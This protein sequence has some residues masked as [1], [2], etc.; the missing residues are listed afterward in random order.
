MRFS[1][2]QEIKKDTSVVD[3]FGGLNHNIRINDGEFFDMENLTSENFPV[4]SPRRKRGLYAYPEEGRHKVNG[5]TAKDV[6]CYVDNSTLYIDNVPVDGFELT[7]TPKTMVSMGAYLIIMPDKKYINTKDFEDN[8]SLEASFATTGITT[9]TM[10]RVDGTEYENVTVSDTAPT[11]PENMAYWIDTSQEPHILKQF[12]SASDSWTVIN[13]TYVRIASAGIAEQFGQYD[14]VRL[15]GINASIEQLKDLEGQTSILWEVHRDEEGDGAGDYIVVVGFLD[16]VVTQDT[17]LEAKRLMPI[18]DFIIES[19]NRL[20]GCRYGTD[21]DGNTVNEIY[22]SKLGDFKNWNSFMGISTDSYAAS[23]GTDGEFTGAVTHGGY[24]LFFK[25]NYLHKVYGNYPANFQV[26]VTECRGVQ[27]GAGRSLAILN[28]VLVYKSRYGVCRYDGSLPVDISPQFG[29]VQYSG[30]E[31]G[32]NEL[33][34]GAVGGTLGK[35]YY[36]SAK[37]EIDGKWCFLVY[38]SEYGTWHKHDETRVD[39]F[40][41]C[42]GEMYFIDHKDKQIKTVFGS[43]DHYEDS[44]KWMAETGILGTSV[45]SGRYSSALTGKK[46]VSQVIVRMSMDVG[47]TAMFYIQ[48]DSCGEW[49]HITTIT[50]THLKSFTTQLRP[51][52]CDHFRIRIIGNGDAKIYSIAKSM[53]RGSEF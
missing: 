20:W 48:Y 16:G 26:Q 41:S 51:K 14:G 39:A 15:S 34:G 50:G 38:D 2:L 30:V 27:K 40:A 3:V 7:D 6:I 13:T 24:P 22:A 19:G 33:T 31:A 42:G 1:Q 36:L 5:L 12:S 29:G 25:E 53:E 21:I 11:N 28:E 49:E 17:V 35:K 4:M 43:G 32:E 18:M 9:Y 8:G 47:S 44:I 23:C 37:S 52:R 45:E 46:Y 10:C